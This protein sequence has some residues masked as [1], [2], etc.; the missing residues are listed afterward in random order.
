MNL[1]LVEDEDVNVAYIASIIASFNGVE[2][3][4]AKSLKDIENMNLEDIQF[5]LVDIY[6]DRTNDGF[7]V[8]D[9]LNKASVPYYTISS[10]TLSFEEIEVLTK[11][12]ALGCLQ[13][14]LLKHEIYSFISANRLLN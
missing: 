11:C 1:L 8:A 12:G 4:A 7:K 10:A 6:L 3:R 2:L 9:Y 14:P 13:K 5:A